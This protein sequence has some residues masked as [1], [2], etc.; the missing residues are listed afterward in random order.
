MIVKFIACRMKNL[1][2]KYTQVFL[3]T[4]DY[5]VGIER[6]AFEDS[7]KIISTNT[8]ILNNKENK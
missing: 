7:L 4:R 1:N 8:Y 3:D 2:W 6:C 5:F